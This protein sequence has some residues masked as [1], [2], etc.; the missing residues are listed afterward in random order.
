MGIVKN[1]VK[2]LFTTPEGCIVLGAASFGGGYL[3]GSA[4]AEYENKR[5]LH[6]YRTGIDLGI[7]FGKEGL[8]KEDISVIMEKEPGLRGKYTARVIRNDVFIKAT[9]EPEKPTDTGVSGN[10]SEA[11][12]A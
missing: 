7:D 11:T 10:S 12:S 9:P 1:V 5:L 6:A 2:W 3:I 4:I 8:N